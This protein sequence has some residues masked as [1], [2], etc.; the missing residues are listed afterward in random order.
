MKIKLL[1][2]TVTRIM[3][4]CSFFLILGCLH[5]S[6]SSLSQT[7][8]VRATAQP[9]EEILSVV[10]GQT[11]YSSAFKKGLLAHVKPVTINIERAQLGDFLDHLFESLPLDYEIEGKT[12]FITAKLESPTTKFASVALKSAQQTI[13]GNVTDT[14]GNS[15][16]GV[17]I[18][19]KNNPAKGTTTDVNGRYILD[20]PNGAVLVFSYVGFTTQELPVEERSVLDVQLMPEV[21]GLEEVAVIGYGTIKRSDLTG[22]VSSVKGED[23]SAF[24]TTSLMKALTGRVSGVQVQ[25]NSGRPGSNISIRIRGTNSIQGSSEPLYVIDG[26]PYSGPPTILNNDDVESIEILKDAS[27][28][29]IYG[30]RGA[31]GVVIITTKQGKSGRFKLDYNGSFGMQTVRKKL[32]MLNAHEYA[33]FYDEQRSNDGLQPYFNVKEGDEFSIENTDWQSE[34]F[35]R[36]PMNSHSLTASGGNDR[37][38][39]SF[40]G[41]FVEQEGIVKNSD[42]GRTSVRSNINFN[43]SQQ[44]QISSNVILSQAKTTTNGAEAGSR[45]SSLI[46]GALSA[47]PTLS[48]FDDDG[49][50]RVLDTAYPFISNSMVNPYNFIREF[51][52]TAITNRA[53]LNSA[54][55]YKPISGLTIKISG[56]LEKGFSRTNSYRTT[57]FVNSAGS[58]AYSTSEL[59][60]LLNENIL[61]YARTLNDVHSFSITG[62]LTYQNYQNT[63]LSASGSGFISNVIESFDIGAAASVNTPSSAYSNW[64]L[65]SYLGRLNYSYNNKYLATVSFR[66]DGSSR[67]SKADKWGHFPSFSLAWR[68]SEEQFV[69]DLVFVSDLKIRAGWG[70]TGNTAIAPYQTLDMLFSGKTAF[71]ETLYTS[72]AP[73]TRQPNNLKWETTEQKD[74]GIDIS[75]FNNRLRLTADYYVKHT[76]D[77]LNTVPLTSSTGYTFTILNIGQVQNKGFELLVEASDIFTKAFK[78]DLSANLSV[79]RNKVI[80]LYNGAD[81]TGSLLNVGTINDY[82]NLLREGYPIGAFYGYREAGYNENG[83]IQYHTADG[84]YSTNPTSRDKVFIGDPNPSFTYGINSAMSFKQ[85]S[86]T[87]FIQGTQGND[88]FNINSV[89]QNLDYGF[90]LNVTKDVFSSHWKPSNSPEQNA[91]AKYPKISRYTSA[92]VSDR[93]VEDGSYLRLQNV[94]LAYNVPMKTSERYTPSSIQIYLSGQNLLTFTKYSWFDPEANYYGGSTSAMQGI[95]HYAYPTAKSI[96]L[97]TRISF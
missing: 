48:P 90:G 46:S 41:G 6:A 60:S 49:K 50:Y 18:T 81:V 94:E 55:I 24:P 78:W 32:D 47:P 84:Q 71:G 91:K 80:K 54:F 73:G 79:N 65:L 42:Y 51:D 77:L 57:D 8:T 52:N 1:T 64:V 63:S 37:V 34:I 22:A 38:N 7:V 45:G 25:Q 75:L 33:I 68:L 62:G 69:K 11:G 61:N 30:S 44:L 36:A 59:S 29:A 85:F 19:V 96:T 88:I 66:S 13:T 26:F 4:L 70:K 10:R 9:L 87:I 17:S 5:L 16:S 95:D 39:F 86:L 23:V 43:V 35:Q 56:G 58:A 28:T 76:K 15:L 14:A 83:L 2:K 67:Y 82:I 89:T 74:I 27:A 12:I 97:G 92:N 31:N 40:G 21:S 93:F 20:V 53:L 3:K 72:Y